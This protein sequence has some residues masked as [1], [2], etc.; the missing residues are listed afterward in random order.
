VPARWDVHSIER[1]M[2]LFGPISSI[3]DYAT[4]GLLILLLGSSQ[5]SAKAFHAGWFVESLFTQILVVLAIRTRMSPFWRSRPSRELAAAIFAALVVAVVVPISPLGSVLGFGALPVTFW[6][7]LVVIVAAYLTMV[8][9]AK[10][11]YDSHEAGRAASAAA[12]HQPVAA[13]PPAATP[14]PAVADRRPA[15]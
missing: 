12:A 2:I 6:L 14:P 3:F 9:I 15:R 10:R 13:P 1:F 11:I 5:D 8:E 7:L 4:F